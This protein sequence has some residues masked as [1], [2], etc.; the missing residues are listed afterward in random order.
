MRATLC[1]A[2]GIRCIKPSSSFIYIA[3]ELAILTT[4]QLT[5]VRAA[6]SLIFDFMAQKF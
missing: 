1:Q 3:Q 6:D 4:P 5:T 2:S